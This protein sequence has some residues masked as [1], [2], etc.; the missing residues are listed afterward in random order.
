MMLI[1]DR[2]FMA[3]MFFGFADSVIAEGALAA[4]G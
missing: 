4:K 2:A 3:S 1:L